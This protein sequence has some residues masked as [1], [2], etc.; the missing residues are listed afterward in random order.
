[1]N[2][3]IG[4]A[5]RTARRAIRWSIGRANTMTDGWWAA[6]SNHVTWNQGQ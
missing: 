6:D 3:A 4:F 2:I 5:T 1:M